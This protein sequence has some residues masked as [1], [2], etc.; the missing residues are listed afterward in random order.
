MMDNKDTRDIL[1]VNASEVPSGEDAAYPEENMPTQ[2]GARPVVSPQEG[3]YFLN[4]FLEQGKEQDA[5]SQPVEGAEDGAPDAPDVGTE[6][7]SAAL[8][9]NA[10]VL[11]GNIVTALR[12][13]YDPEIPVNIYEMGLIYD[14]DVAEDFSVNVRMTLTTPNCPVAESRP[15]EVEMKVAGVTGVK[16]VEVK[17]VW[18]PPWDMSRMSD[19]ARLELG[20]L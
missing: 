15:G 8:P 9:E 1:D 14:V 5:A 7:T 10:E 2:A 17:L 6:V 11:Q 4:K 18:E 3:G 16:S 13:I 12:E 20:L 19:E